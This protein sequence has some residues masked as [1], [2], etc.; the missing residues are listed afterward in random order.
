MQAEHCEGTGR[1]Q[2][3]RGQVRERD[4]LTGHWSH[5]DWPQLDKPSL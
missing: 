2:A 4:W 1:V 3:A 5:P